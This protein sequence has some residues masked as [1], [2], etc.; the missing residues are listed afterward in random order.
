MKNRFF[1]DFKV[2]NK[3]NDGWA[4]KTELN[5]DDKAKAV[6]KFH[7]VCTQYINTAQ[8]DHVLVVLSD[9]YGNALETEVW[10]EEK[11]EEV[12]E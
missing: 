7:E 11:E 9:A 1:V 3:E 4:Y 2:H 10:D 6:K 5:T 8:F 12:A